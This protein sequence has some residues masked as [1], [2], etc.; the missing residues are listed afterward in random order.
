[1]LKSTIAMAIAIASAVELQAQLPSPKSDYIHLRGDVASQA[2]NVLRGQ[3]VEI[4]SRTSAPFVLAHGGQIVWKLVRTATDRR[5]GI[6]QTYE[7]YYRGPEGEAQ[8]MGSGIIV[9]YR[10]E[11]PWALTGRQFSSIA[12]KNKPAFSATEAVDRA[13]VRLQTHPTFR[14]EPLLA[15]TPERRAYRAARTRLQLVQIDGVFRFVYETFAADRAGI[16]SAVFIDAETGEV[17]GFAPTILKS[18]CAAGSGSVAS[19]TGIPVRTADLSGVTRS[20]T[21]KASSSRPS[22]YTYEAYDQP[23]SAIFTVYQQ[24]R[25]SAFM[26]NSSFTDSYTLFPLQTDSGIPTYK[27]R[28]SDPEWQGN[29]AGD[30]LYH[31][32]QALNALGRNGWDGSGSETKIVLES[33]LTLT[34]STAFVFDSFGDAKVPGND[35]VVIGKSEYMYNMASCLDA[36]GHEWGHG[37]IIGSANFTLGTDAGKQLHEGWADVVGQ[38]VEKLVEPSGTGVERS[39]DWVLHEDAATSGYARGAIDDD[40]DGYAGH[41]WVGPNG[42]HHFDDTVHKD[43]TTITE[44][45]ARGNMMNVVFKLLADGGVNPACGQSRASTW[46]GVC[47]SVTGRGFTTAKDILLTTLQYYLVSSSEWDDLADAATE[48]AFDLY[49]NCSVDNH[50]DASPEQSSVGNA[51]NA[52]G[53][54]RQN[55]H[56]VCP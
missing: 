21:A 54:P 41:D 15:L 33:T 55:P 18:N 32:I 9:H 27:D 44:P 13:L 30:A 34:D 23:S 31:S 48:A 17:L 42:T 22:P 49:E 45:H 40:A 28:S 24:T 53:Y 4:S 6:H 10:N 14:A 11:K 3:G 52:I 5:G 35:V 38:S 50:A 25:T 12:I 2:P 51:F 46:S 7:Q 39:D 47:Q 56:Y 43:D 26:C 1:M 36:I 8:V 16:H 37:L 20:L 19:A 29:A